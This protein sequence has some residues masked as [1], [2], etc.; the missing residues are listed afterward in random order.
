MKRESL[1]VASFHIHQF[2]DCQKGEEFLCR[3][4]QNPRIKSS[5]LTSTVAKQEFDETMRTKM[6]YWSLTNME[7]LG[8]IRA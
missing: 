5:P 6:H 3:A 8:Y 1:S 2:L 4:T 7:R